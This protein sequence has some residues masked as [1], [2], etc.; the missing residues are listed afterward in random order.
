MF[1]FLEV[2]RENS[3]INHAMAKT[4]KSTEKTVT[5]PARYQMMFLVTVSI[6]LVNE[7]PGE[8]TFCASRGYE[9][10]SN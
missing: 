10:F 8:R 5:A 9:N 6:H 1:F 4:V 2:I 3:V 7:V